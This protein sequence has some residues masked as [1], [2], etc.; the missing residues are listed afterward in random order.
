MGPGSGIFVGFTVG[1]SGGGGGLLDDDEVGNSSFLSGDL[2]FNDFFLF[3][4]FSFQ[5]VN[6]LLCLNGI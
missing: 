3:L 1:G 2:G 6:L 4:D 5:L